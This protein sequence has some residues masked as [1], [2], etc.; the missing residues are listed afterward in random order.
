MSKTDSFMKRMRTKQEARAKKAEKRMAISALLLQRETLLQ[1]RKGILDAGARPDSCI[2]ST[3]LYVELATRM[4]FR[5][6]ES[7]VEATV[8][9]PAAAELARDFDDYA[10]TVFGPGMDDDLAKAMMATEARTVVLGSHDP[11]LDG[12]LGE[13]KWAGHLVAILE[14]HAGQLHLIDLSLDQATRP[15]KRILLRPT[16]FPIKEELLD[17]DTVARLVMQT[18]DGECMVDYIVRPNGTGYEASKDW[19]RKFEPILTTHGDKMQFSV[20]E[21]TDDGEPK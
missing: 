1:V 7:V 11:E 2:L 8:M 16:G 21:F 5:C 3:K 20:R 13:N 6:R 10:G 17:G 15:K 14:D 12:P 18:P 9:N 4:G 19:N